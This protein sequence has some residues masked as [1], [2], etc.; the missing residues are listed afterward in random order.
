MG[1]PQPRFEPQSPG[2]ELQFR[3]V[4]LMAGS[5][6]F[7]IGLCVPESAKTLVL[8]AGDSRTTLQAGTE[9]ARSLVGAGMAVMQVDAPERPSGAAR[10]EADAIGQWAGR[11]IEAAR[12][13]RTRALVWDMPQGLLGAGR[14]AAAAIEAAAALDGTV[15]AL[16]VLE[17]RL[18]LVSRVA[19]ALNRA[20]T[21]VLVQG[22]SQPGW[23]PQAGPV[24]CVLRRLPA[25]VGGREVPGTGALT[26]AR[27]WLARHLFPA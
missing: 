27:T 4:R 6:A 18:D 17:P 15:G 25:A 12:W 1:L 16:V 2:L 13:A 21:L 11:L 26:E 14:G 10:G 8:V 7:E 22:Q 19:L 24:E 23:M 3:P 9:M 20:P 5:D